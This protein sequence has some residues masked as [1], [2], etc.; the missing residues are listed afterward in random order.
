VIPEFHAEAAGRLD[1]RVG[2]QAD[3]DDAANTVLLGLKIKTRVGK[4]AGSPV[5]LRNDFA[6]PGLSSH[7]AN[8]RTP[9]LPPLRYDHMS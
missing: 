4:T 6:R 8:F 1:T 3:Q 9:P 2:D 5:L 7:L